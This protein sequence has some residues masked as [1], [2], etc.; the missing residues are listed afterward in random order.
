MSLASDLRHLSLRRSPKLR[1]SAAASLGCN[2][3]GSRKAAPASRNPNSI[4]RC[5]ATRVS[6]QSARP[7]WP[8]R[9]AMGARP[10]GGDDGPEQPDHGECCGACVHSRKLIGTPGRLRTC[11]GF[12]CGGFRAAGRIQRAAAATL[13]I[14]AH[15]AFRQHLEFDQPPSPKR[16]G[17]ADRPGTAPEPCR[18]CATSCLRRLPEDGRGGRSCHLAFGHADRPVAHPAERPGAVHGGDA[19]VGEQEIEGHVSLP[20]SFRR[21]APG[22]P[23]SR[24][25]R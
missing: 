22:S 2:A 23:P 12:P 15:A 16:C 6:W 18:R 14:P 8:I 3:A 24:T 13:D 17:C 1:C 25:R 19:G 7:C 20:A 10:L 4:C 5:R 11:H 21:A 9:L